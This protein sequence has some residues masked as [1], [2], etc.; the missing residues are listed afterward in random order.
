MFNC[1]R[2]LHHACND[3]GFEQDL[4][5]TAYILFCLKSTQ[6][7]ILKLNWISLSGKDVF[8][9]NISYIQFVPFAFMFLSYIY[10]IPRNVRGYNS[11]R[12]SQRRHFAETN[13]CGFVVTAN[14]AN[15]KSLQPKLQF[16]EATSLMHIIACW[17]LL[18][19][20]FFLYNAF[21]SID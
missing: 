14:S 15:I 16:L 9:I 12:F 13:F 3:N 17:V 7:M 20:L 19:L 1:F 6:A 11:S 8:S 5:E 18:I 2:N 10:C 4:G 21:S